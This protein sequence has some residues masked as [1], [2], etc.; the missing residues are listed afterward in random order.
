MGDF[1]RL[2]KEPPPLGDCSCGIHSS[3]LAQILRETQS[4]VSWQESWLFVYDAR[5]DGEAGLAGKYPDSHKQFDPSE[6]EARRG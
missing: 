5:E 1:S 3:T 6:R 4:I 2:T